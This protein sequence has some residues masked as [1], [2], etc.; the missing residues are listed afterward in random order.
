MT[1]SGAGVHAGDSQQRQGLSQA[2]LGGAQA[3]ATARR[4]A[5]APTACRTLCGPGGHGDRSLR[6][7]GQAGFSGGQLRSQQERAPG[8][9]QPRLWH[10]PGWE[11][12]HAV[13]LSLAGGARA[14]PTSLAQTGSWGGSARPGAL[15]LPLLC[16]RPGCWAPHRAPP[17]EEPTQWAHPAPRPFWSGS[18]H[19][20][21]AMG[22]QR[23]SG[24]QAAA[25][26]GFA[27]SP[28]RQRAASGSLDPSPRASS[29]GTPG[30][31]A[32]WPPPPAPPHPK[33]PLGRCREEAL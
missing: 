27:G 12:R 5:P 18:E 33:E 22:R 23:C 26:Q 3:S 4:P 9:G 6:G 8:D 7:G 19:L 11:R 25:Q 21:S 1:R 28:A 14:A 17:R 32:S 29:G 20:W 2:A 16:P 24:L 31:E 10:F 13:Q 30:S 15:H